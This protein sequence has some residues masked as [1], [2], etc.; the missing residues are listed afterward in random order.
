M[1][2]KLLLLFAILLTMPAYAS[3]GHT[4]LDINLNYGIYSHFIMRPYYIVDDPF[5]DYEFV[6]VRYRHRY[7]HHYKSY[8]HCRRCHQW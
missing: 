7:R 3:H 5:Y 4:H 1:K 8:R 2:N 6:D